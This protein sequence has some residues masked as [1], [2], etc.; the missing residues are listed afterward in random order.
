MSAASN[1]Y[2]DLYH[3]ANWGCHSVFAWKPWGTFQ[4]RGSGCF[5]RKCSFCTYLCAPDAGLWPRTSLIPQA[6][7]PHTD[8][9]QLYAESAVWFLQHPSA[10]FSGCD[11]EMCNPLWWIFMR[12]AGVTR[13]GCTCQHVQPQLISTL[14]FGLCFKYQQRNWESIPHCFLVY[15]K[16]LLTAS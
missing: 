11:L 7:M 8:V 3:Y 2:T 14:D 15:V 10:A 12:H 1:S 5:T 4:P 13:N 16:Q 6:A 9:D